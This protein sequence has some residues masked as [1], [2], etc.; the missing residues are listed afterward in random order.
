MPL[1]P[2]SSQQVI[3]DNIKTERAAGKP[4]KVAIAI[5]ESEARRTGHTTHPHKVGQPSKHY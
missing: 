2:G 1:E 5:A 4:E 3:S